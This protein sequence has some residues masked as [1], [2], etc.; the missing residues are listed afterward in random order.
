MP[1]PDE[2][3][4][5]L[6]DTEGFIHSFKSAKTREFIDTLTGQVSFTRFLDLRTSNSERD[7]SLAFFDTCVE[8]HLDHSADE[9]KGGYGSGS[10]ADPFAPCT[11]LTND[12]MGVC[13]VM[14]C[15]MEQL[16]RCCCVMWP[17]SGGTQRSHGSPARRHRTPQNACCRRRI[18]KTRCIGTK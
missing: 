1:N 13:C 8:A 4:A 2:P 6:F 10:Y 14:C 5:Q 7:P 9:T 15:V 11:Y 18:S 17:S 12:V 3:F 16:P